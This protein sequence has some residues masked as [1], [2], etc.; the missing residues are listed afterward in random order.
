M[1][2]VTV[3]EMLSI[4]KEADESGISYEMMM[5]NAG[6]GLAEWVNTHEYI[7]PG[8]IGLIGAGNNGGD[9]LIALTRLSRLGYRTIGFLVKQREKDS[10][11]ENYLSA[12]GVTVDIS[13]NRNLDILAGALSPNVVVL[14]G[15]LGTGLKLP[16]RGDIY[17]VMGNIHKLMKNRPEARKIAVD[18]PS[19]VDC[20]TGEVS[21]VTIMADETLCLAAIK[22][23]LLEYP[24]RSFTGNLHVVDIGIETHLQSLDHINTQMISPSFVKENLP[25]RPSNGHKGTFGTCLVIAGSEPYVGAAYLAGRSAYRSGCG[26]VH[27]ASMDCVHKSLSGELIEAVWTVLPEKNN[28][29]DA[30]GVDILENALGSSDACVVGPGWGLQEDNLEFLGALLNRIPENLPILVDADGLK[31]ISRIDLWWEKLPKNSILTPHPGEMAILTG[32]SIDEIQSNRWLVAEKYAKHWQTILVLKGAVT[33]IGTPQG[34]LFVNPVAD[35]SLATAGSGDVLSG[36]IGGLMAQGLSPSKAAI[37]GTWLHAQAGLNAR[38]SLGTD[39]SVMATDILQG[40]GSAFK[41]AA[42]FL[43]S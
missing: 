5:H 19:G 17:G 24:A 34:E 36:L 8:V 16:I 20:D 28:A 18:C 14:D 13:Q 41:S 31:H 25:A 40:M 33:V 23:G 6:A 27:I 12:G 7:T 39:V 10:L 2:I 1:K 43:I 38:L 32:L 26:L 21:D 42:N 29:Y 3:E 15:I 30:S 4:E 35:P 9:T 22:R 37:T 11:S